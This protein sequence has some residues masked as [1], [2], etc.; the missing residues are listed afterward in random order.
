MGH[1]G[2]R[3]GENAIEFDMLLRYILQHKA[4]DCRQYKPN[5]LKR[6]VGVRIRAT[7][8]EGYAGYLKLLKR[9]PGEFKR[10]IDDL[11]INVTEFFRDP[12]VFQAL[13]ERVLP[14]MV[15]LK[16]RRKSYTIRAWSAGCAT[17]EEP[18]SLAIL[19]ADYLS[20]Q[21]DRECWAVRI[22]ATDLDEG[23]LQV[24]REAFYLNVEPLPELEWRKYF[25]ERGEGLQ[26]RD[27]IR[28]MVKF[29][30]VDL[31][32]PPAFRYLDLILCRNVLIYFGKEMQRKILWFFHDSL[33]KDGFLVLGKSEAIVG[34]GGPPFEP[35]M[36]RERI[37]RKET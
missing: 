29:A 18:Y 12:D 7:G 4:F 22:T 16:R 31:M 13:R 23:S 25:V 32:H 10:L 37:Y 11:T 15:E 21:K 17:G 1:E 2:V 30:R 27:D 19:I 28:Q 5:Y 8:A 33:R 20:R 26:V 14:E 9:D 35:Y 6:R 24:A 34:T 3:A 36:R